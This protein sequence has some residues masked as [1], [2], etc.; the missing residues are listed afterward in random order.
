MIKGERTMKKKNLMIIKNDN[1]KIGKR[2]KEG[3]E[4]RNKL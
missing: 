1:R 3:W 2:N 4:I